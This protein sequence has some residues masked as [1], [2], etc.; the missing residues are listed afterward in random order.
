MNE[1]K[2]QKVECDMTVEP[3][4]V[5]LDYAKS[6]KEWEQR[7]AKSKRILG[8]CEC[9]KPKFIPTVDNQDKD[10]LTDLGEK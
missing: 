10:Q 1:L 6:L 5:V 2:W 8:G 7:S 3:K 4:Q 9:C